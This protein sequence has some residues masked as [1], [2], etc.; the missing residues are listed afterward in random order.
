MLL[1]Q[2]LKRG[3]WELLDISKNEKTRERSKG[4][5]IPTATHR[6]VVRKTV[7]P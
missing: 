2:Y 1:N 5:A 4:L 3:E 6:K 7:L